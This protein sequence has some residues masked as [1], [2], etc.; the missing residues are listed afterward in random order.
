M[1]GS[2]IN[3]AMTPSPSTIYQPCQQLSKELNEDVER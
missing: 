2:Q 1:K 3:H